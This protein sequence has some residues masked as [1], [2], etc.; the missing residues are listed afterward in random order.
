MLDRCIVFGVLFPT[1][2]VLQLPVSVPI[3]DTIHRPVAAF[4]LNAIHL[5]SACPQL[6]LIHTD[7]KPA[8]LGTEIHLHLHP[9]MFW[10]I[11]DTGNR[12]Q[13]KLTRNILVVCCWCVEPTVGECEGLSKETESWW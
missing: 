4:C 5:P 8:G 9:K 11:N 10:Q 3:P 7:S 6:R 2:V 1:P 13:T 12:P